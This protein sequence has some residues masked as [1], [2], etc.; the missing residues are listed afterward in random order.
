MFV[1]WAACAEKRRGHDGFVEMTNSCE[2]KSAG[3]RI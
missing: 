1:N 2:V 3:F